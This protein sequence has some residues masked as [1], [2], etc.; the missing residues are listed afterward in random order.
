MYARTQGHLGYALHRSSQWV[1]RWLANDAPAK[2]AGRGYPV[3]AWVRFFEARRGEIPLA[4]EE[5]VPA[6]PKRAK[7]Y[8][9]AELR[10]LKVLRQRGELVERERHEAELVAL[11]RLMVGVLDQGTVGIASRSARQAYRA[12]CL[13]VRRQLVAKLG[14]RARPRPA[15]RPAVRAG[16]AEGGKTR[17]RIKKGGRRHGADAGRR[18]DD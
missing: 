9:D 4:D 5:G 3:G 2:R 17:G 18:K 12:A 15:A 6:D 7:D 10:R 16:A 14:G 13:A 11:G 1:A 8:W